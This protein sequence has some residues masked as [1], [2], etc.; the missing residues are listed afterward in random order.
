MD[1]LDYSNQ[2]L[3]CIDYNIKGHN[4]YIVNLHENHA[5]FSIIFVKVSDE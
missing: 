4:G 1:Y 2:T 3:S 5:S